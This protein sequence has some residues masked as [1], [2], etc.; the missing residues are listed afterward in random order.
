M[1]LGRARSW[2]APDA[3]LE[4]ARLVGQ[5][6][7]VL[8]LFAA[9]RALPDGERELLLL[10]ALDGLTPTEAGAALG[11]PAGTARSRLHRARARIREQLDAAEPAYTAPIPLTS[12][13]I[14][15]AIA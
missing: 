11:I 5:T 3:R 10:V 13:L 6:V 8:R 14:P 15:G 1:R 7:H 12:H 9:V 2:A 4:R